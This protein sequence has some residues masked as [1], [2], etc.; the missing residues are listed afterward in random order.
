MSRDNR[1]KRRSWGESKVR[2]QIMLT[3]TALE[4][5]SLM[6]EEMG[7][8]RSEIIERAIRSDCMNADTLRREEG[9][10]VQAICWE[11]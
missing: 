3:P 7:L 4:L 6:A 1:V 9:A 5:V 2:V 11:A 8:S 10:T